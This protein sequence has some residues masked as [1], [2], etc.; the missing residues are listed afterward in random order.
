MAS[1]LH[2]RDL[3]RTDWQARR[4]KRYG[5]MLAEIVDI[6]LEYIDESYST[7]DASAFLAASGKKKIPIDAAAAAVIL[8]RY[9]DRA[10]NVLPAAG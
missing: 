9:L 8:Q 10:N 7:A 2:L 6:P 4:V 5:D 3:P 1:Y